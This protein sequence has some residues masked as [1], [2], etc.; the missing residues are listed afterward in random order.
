MI[1]I[2]NKMYPPEIGGV[3]VVTKTIAE[4]LAEKYDVTVLTFNKENKFKNEKVKNIEILRLPSFF[5]K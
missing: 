2:V 3:E 4:I 1:L 5:T